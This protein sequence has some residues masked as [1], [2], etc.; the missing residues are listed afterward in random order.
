MEKYNWKLHLKISIILSII[1]YL[2]V[3]FVAWDITVIKNI[4]SIHLSGRALICVLYIGL[5]SLIAVN[6]HFKNK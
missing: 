2:I 4:G 3:S 5:N 1:S 6:I